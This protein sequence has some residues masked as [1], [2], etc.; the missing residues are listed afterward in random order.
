MCYGAEVRVFFDFIKPPSGLVAQRFDWPRRNK[1]TYCGVG[2]W[3]PASLISLIGWFDSGLRILSWARPTNNVAPVPDPDGGFLFG[4][5]MFKLKNL[6]AWLSNFLKLMKS[7]SD[8]DDNNESMVFGLGVGVMPMLWRR[9]DGTWAR[10]VISDGFQRR[11]PNAKRGGKG[12]YGCDLAEH[13]DESEP[14][15]GSKKYPEYARYYFCPSD[16]VAAVACVA[17][18]VVRI[19]RT[20]NGTAVYL[21]CGRYMIVYRHLKGVIVRK[22]QLLAMGDSIGIVSHAPKN[23]DGFNHLHFEIWDTKRRGGRWNRAKKA[24]DPEPFIREWALARQQPA[25]TDRKSDQ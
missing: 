4:E 1:L 18:R 24:I 5:I 16:V 10:F 13:R 14:G 23:K 2:Q 25:S 9:P 17:G 3:L 20:G 15:Y 22:G 6:E 19:T 7:S 21:K 12:H 11:G 8:L